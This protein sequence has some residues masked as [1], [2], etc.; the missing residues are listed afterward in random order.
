MVEKRN[1]S[2]LCMQ[3][4]SCKRNTLCVGRNVQVAS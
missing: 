4:T 3:E 2:V 1:V